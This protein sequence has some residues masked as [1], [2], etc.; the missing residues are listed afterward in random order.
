MRR[1]AIT[2][3]VCLAFAS[4]VAAQ[5]GD[6]RRTASGRPDLI[7]AVGNVPI[8]VGPISP[9]DRNV[10]VSRRVDELAFQSLRPNR[11]IQTFRPNLD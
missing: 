3:L 11:S 10:S 4:A 8:A 9:D 1:I 5:D 7:A 6:I 2:V